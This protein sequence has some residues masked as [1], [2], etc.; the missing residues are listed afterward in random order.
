MAGYYLYSLNWRKFTALVERPTRGQ[1]RTLVN[2]LDE[3]RDGRAGGLEEGD[4][5]RDWLPGAAALAPF[6]AHRLPRK[7]WYGDLLP[8]AQRLWA[9]AVYTACMWDRLGQ[10]SR[11]HDIVYWDTIEVVWKRLGVRPETPGKKAMSRFGMVPF[12]YRLPKRPTRYSL[13]W[14]AHSMH[15]PAEVRRMRAELR[16]VAPALEAAKDTDLRPKYTERQLR[17]LPERYRERVA[18]DIRREFSEVLPPTVVWA[19]AK[20]RLLFVAVDT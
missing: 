5:A 15:P 20:G 3:Q 16:S 2:A 1:L 18:A 19:A 13:N 14:T 7:D 10:V 8:H 6:V 17:M 12:R 11:A 9:R 4:P